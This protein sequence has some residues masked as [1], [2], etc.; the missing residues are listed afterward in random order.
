M[1]PEKERKRVFEL[2]GVQ[3]QDSAYQTGIKVKEICEITACLYKNYPDWKQRLTDFDLEKRKNNIVSSLSGGERQ[4]L[5]ILLAFIHS[6]KVVFLDELTT[7]LD[8][9][10]RR[11]TWKFIKRIQSGRASVI[12]TSHFMDEVETLCSR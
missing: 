5:S 8:P 7:R 6:P 3:F 11:D 10:A 4:K 2:T 1:N 12:L 9:A